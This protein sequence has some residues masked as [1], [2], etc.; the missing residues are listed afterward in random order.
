MTD[1]TNFSPPAVSYMPAPKFKYAPKQTEIDFAQLIATGADP[2]EAIVFSG[3]VTQEGADRLGR[4]ELYRMASRLIRMEAVQ[5]RIDF[6]RQL[7]KSSMS[8]TV[9]RMLQ[10]LAGMAFS[11]IADSYQLNGRPHTNPHDIPRYARAAIKEFYIDKDGVVRIKL[12]DKLK[13]QQL[14]GDLEGYFNE[15]H[16][17]KAPQVTVNLG[18]TPDKDGPPHRLART[19]NDPQ[20]IEAEYSEGGLS[21]DDEVPDF[22][23]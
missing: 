21:E 5:E 20:V 8:V 19:Q 1:D 23:K 2:V 4:G 15:A 14:I 11:D 6:F 12:H 9:E 22:L 18:S 3:I 16:R 13:A 7:H 17:A 10:E